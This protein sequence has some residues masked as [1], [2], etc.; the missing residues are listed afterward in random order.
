M[1]HPKFI[2]ENDNLIIGE[3]EFH[4]DLAT[5]TK[6]VK[7]GGWYEFNEETKMF[8]LYG[9][10]FDFGAANLDDIKRCVELKN[11]FDT[12][13]SRNFFDK[14]EN[15]FN[16]YTFAYKAADGELTILKHTT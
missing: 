2:I 3:V 1:K 15:V 14:I 11:V 8:V 7:G 10:S 6:D 16:K 12:N 13:I 5:N 9:K 4:R